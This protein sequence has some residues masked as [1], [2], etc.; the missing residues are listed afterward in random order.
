VLDENPASSEYTSFELS[1]LVEGDCTTFDVNVLIKSKVTALK[2]LVHE[3]RKRGLLREVDPA[4][5]MEVNFVAQLSTLRQVD[6]DLNDHDEDSLQSLVIT[7]DDKGVHKLMGWK[8]ISDYWAVQPAND[9]LHVFV[10]LPATGEWLFALA[11][12]HW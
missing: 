2:E 1:C 5:L 3:K 10:K 6:V 12:G 9:R 4:D 11:Y 7:K 8:P